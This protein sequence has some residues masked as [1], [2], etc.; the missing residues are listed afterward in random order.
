MRRQ[1]LY[2]KVEDIRRGDTT[3][4]FLQKYDTH[5]MTWIMDYDRRTGNMELQFQEVGIKRYSLCSHISC[6]DFGEH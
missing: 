1:G 4:F 2:F 5:E 6:D 3:N